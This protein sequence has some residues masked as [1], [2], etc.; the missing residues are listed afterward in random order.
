VQYVISE[1][2]LSDYL[3]NTT[4]A[5]PAKAS[6]ANMAGVQNNP[7]LKGA[8]NSAK[9]V[10]AQPFI[11]MLTDLDLELCSLAQAVTVGGQDVNSAIA[12]FTKVVQA[13]L[14]K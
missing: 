12:N 10:K 13:K 8:A 3:A 2:V 14:S 4:P 9:N 6:M 7:I 5:Y 11:P 1:K